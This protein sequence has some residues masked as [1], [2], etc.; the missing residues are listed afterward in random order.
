MFRFAI[1]IS[2]HEM[3][4]LWNKEHD[5]IK[6]GLNQFADLTKEEFKKSYLGYKKTAT[7]KPKQVSF[8]KSV[9]VNTTL[10]WRTKNAVS[11]IKN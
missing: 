5:E 3:I 1:F 9:A 2:T 4:E 6:L 11:S 7:T 8:N 10:D